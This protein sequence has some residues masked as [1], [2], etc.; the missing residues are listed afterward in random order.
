MSLKDERKK[1]NLS[2][3]ELAEKSGVSLRTIQ[4]YE[5]TA[6]NID[7]CNLH[8]LIMLCKALDCKLSDIVN[9]DELRKEIMKGWFL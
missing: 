1:A 8:S 7:G 4:A 5:C 3:A 6:R 9:D 2:Q